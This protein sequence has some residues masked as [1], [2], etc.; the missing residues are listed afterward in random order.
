[1]D[2][3]NRWGLQYASQEQ[4]EAE[5]AQIVDYAFQTVRP[6]IIQAMLIF[7]SAPLTATSFMALE[8]QLIYLMRQLGRAL[9]QAVVQSLETVDG[10]S[11]PRDL[12]FDCGLYRRRSDVTANSSLSTMFGNIVLMR[13]GY[14]S[15]LPGEKTIFPIELMLGISNN[16]SPALLDFIGK[17][18]AATGQSQ[19]ATLTIVR[20][21]CDV[22]MGVKRL[23]ACIEHLAAAMEPLRQASQVDSLLEVLTQAQCSSGNRKPVLSV[24][25]DGITLRSHKH[26]F[27]EVATA[28]TISVYD[29]AGKRLRTIYLAFPPELGQAT[30]DTMITQLLTALFMRWSGPLPRLAYVTDSGS[31]EIEYYRQVL[32]KMLHPVTGKLMQ[33][34]R[35]ADFYHASERV[36]A[37][38]HA[39]FGEDNKQQ[40][41]A[42]ATRMLKTLK[43]PCGASRVLHSAASLY[44]RRELSKTRQADY[45]RAYRY[46]QT[47]LQHLRYFEFS[48]QHLPL[49]S[50]VTEAA[51]K[52]IFTQRLKLSGMA[53]TQ[54]GAKNILTLRSILLSQTWTSTYADYL[55]QHQTPKI[56]TYQPNPTSTR[57]K[58]LQNAA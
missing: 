12:E 31:N 35:V 49:G 5:V 9:L 39:L 50:G 56:L 3:L 17:T 58:P 36:W 30:M 43:K 25:R 6:L 4:Q 47:R 52:T 26:G 15:R 55:K 8:L 51:C 14:R 21:Q 11:A 18:I 33:W 53:W 45:L 13:T 27:F 29:R 23:R 38:A 7:L 22:S 16:V 20:E 41:A 37:M 32:R 1:M 54:S 2:K 44:H 46:I 40:S 48:Q 10:W 28:A 42:W 34:T 24:G 57:E 19:Q